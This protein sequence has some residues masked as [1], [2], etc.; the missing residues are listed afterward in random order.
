M[1]VV[2]ESI[3]L[4]GLPGELLPAARSFGGRVWLTAQLHA[5][6]RLADPRGTVSLRWRAAV[7]GRFG[8]DDIIANAVLAG[9]RAHLTVDAAVNGPGRARIQADAPFHVP[10][11]MPLAV[12][13]ETGRISASFSGIEGLG[14]HRIAGTASAGFVGGRTW[15]RVDARTSEGELLRAAATAGVDWAAIERHGIA[16]MLHDLPGGIPPAAIS[17]EEAD[18]GVAAAAHLVP[19]TGLSSLGGKVSGTFAV[20]G[21]VLRGRLR[22]EGARIDDFRPID[23][24]L[25]GEATPRDAHAFARLTDLQGGEGIVTASATR[26]VEGPAHWTMQA[27]VVDLPLGSPGGSGASPP[28]MRNAAVLYGHVDAAA[29]ISGAGRRID[30]WLYGRGRDLVLSGSDV[31]D[32]VLTGIVDDTGVVAWAGMR[33][34]TGGRFAAVARVSGDPTTWAREPGTWSA[35]PLFGALVA[36]GIPL[37]PFTIFVG[38]GLNMEGRVDARAVVRG[39]PGAPDPHLRLSIRDGGIVAPQVGHLRDV[40]L[41]LTA[42]RTHVTLEDVVAH[43]GTGTAH[44]IA[45][46]IRDD[47]GKW[48]LDG[49]VVADAFQVRGENIAGTIDAHGRLGGAFEYPALAA[50]LTVDSATIRLPE[51]L[52]RS[53]QSLGENPDFVTLSGRRDDVR[54]VSG[55]EANKPKRKRT[56]GSA[57]TTE[58]HVEVPDEIDIRGNDIS[59]AIHGALTVRTGGTRPVP[60]LDGEIEARRGKSTLGGVTLDVDHAKVTFPGAPAK[61]GRLDI[62][63]THEMDDADKTKVF[64]A[65]LGTIGKPRIE[66]TSDPPLPQNQIISMVLLGTATGPAPAPGTGGPPG[67]TSAVNPSTGHAAT[68]VGN[69]LTAQLRRQVKTVI[70]ID[71]F[72]L[73]PGAFGTGSAGKLRVGKYIAP[74]LFLSYAHAFSVTTDEA[75]NTLR[76]EYQFHRVWQLVGEYSDANTGQVGVVWKHDF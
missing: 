24:E 42:D 18:L 10:L 58:L 55:T 12:P 32:A 5:I 56:P 34:A 16:A 67:T 50:S 19:T 54:A 51:Q 63:A 29:S 45:S 47:A 75:A 13:A 72:E 2:A 38:R 68:F 30:G 33:P 1:L 66:I 39:S 71:V 28:S 48:T 46:A 44:A 35:S 61:D 37:A 20:A 31:G 43:G 26:P 25:A 60:W 36:R 14:A 49:T 41:A 57:F 11:R 3:A 59:A 70:P 6:P 7:Y 23:V 15:A 62:R 52:P 17:I 21:D 69:Y 22:V 76:L 74:G 8:A 40:E 65:V 4:P 53:L 64:L 27:A 9:G 73:E